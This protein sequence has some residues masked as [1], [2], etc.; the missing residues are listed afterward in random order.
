MDELEDS[1]YDENEDTE[2]N[3]DLFEPDYEINKEESDEDKFEPDD[4]LGEKETDGER[5]EPDY[6]LGEKEADENTFEPDYELGEKEANEDTFE[7]DYELDEKEADEDVFEPDYQLD[8]E[9]AETYENIDS[10][11]TIL[12][13]ENSE[14]D[15]EYQQEYN[16]ESEK[17]HEPEEDQIEKEEE[18]VEPDPEEY[19]NDQEPIYDPDEIS[20]I[21]D[22]EE[23]GSALKELHK[24]VGYSNEELEEYDN[25]AFNAEQAY[26]KMKENEQDFEEQAAEQNGENLTEEIKEGGDE[27]PKEITDSE[28][29][30]YLWEEYDRLEQEGKSLEEISELMHEAEET[31]Q[32][33]KN[34]EE[35][36]E[37]IYERQEKQDLE[38]INHK[39]E[40]ESED[41]RKE[42]ENVHE[43]EY[44][45]D[46]E[47][48]LQAE[49][50]SPEKITEGMQEVEDSYEFVEEVEAHFEQQK[51]EKLKSV[52]H[53]DEED[54]EEQREEID[55]V[56]VIECVMEA[57]E[58]FHE[59]G[60]SQEKIDEETEKIA[61]NFYKSEV[62]ELQQKKQEKG[63]SE[64]LG[65][66]ET[67]IT[68][69]ELDLEEQDRINHTSVD[70]NDE[71][72]GIYSEMEYREVL[73]EI[74]SEYKDKNDVELEQEGINES[75]EKENKLEPKESEEEEYER[76]QQL[77]RQETGK[78]PI[79]RRRE[80]IG[81]SEWLEHQKLKTKKVEEKEEK[82]QEEERWKRILKEWIKESKEEMLNSELK[83]VLKEILQEYEVLEDLCRKSVK[84]NLAETERDKWISYLRKYLNKY[85]IHLH[86]LQNIYGFKV[87][88]QECHPWEIGQIKYKFIRHLAKKY[89]TLKREYILYKSLKYNLKN[90]KDIEDISNLKT[91]REWEKELKNQIEN[92]IKT[93]KLPE[94]FKVRTLQIYYDIL[95]SIRDLGNKMVFSVFYSSLGSRKDSK[96]TAAALIYVLLRKEKHKISQKDLAGCLR[97]HR[98]AIT[99]VLQVL[100]NYLMKIP[101]HIYIYDITRSEG[102]SIDNFNILFQNLAKSLREININLTDYDLK[103]IKLIIDNWK[104][105]IQELQVK[106]F[107][108]LSSTIIYIY[109][110]FY[111]DIKIYQ[112][113]FV[114]L[115][116]ELTPL[117]LNYSRFSMSF[118]DIFK[119]YFRLNINNYKQ[120]MINYL[121]E[122][123]NEIEAPLEILESSIKLFEYAK[124][125]K[126]KIPFTSVHLKTPITDLKILHIDKDGELHYIFPQE[127]S[128][129]LLYYNLKRFEGFEYFASKNKFKEYF[130][131]LDSIQ[132]AKIKFKTLIEANRIHPLIKDVLGRL[133]RE[134]F[135]KENFIEELKT[136]LKRD[137][138]YDTD[139]ILKLYLLNLKNMPNLTPQNYIEFLDIYG[140]RLGSYYRDLVIDK[141]S[142]IHPRVFKKISKYIE[143]YLSGVERDH[144]RELFSI[145]TKKRQEEWNKFEKKYKFQWNK[146]NISLIQDI[147]VL[148]LLYNYLKSISLGQF[149]LNLFL[150]ETTDRASRLKLVAK[151]PNQVKT[152]VIW[153]FFKKVKKLIYKFP[154]NLDS[155]K[156]LEIVK[157]VYNSPNFL[158]SKAHDILQDN[159]INLNY[160]K[161]GKLNPIATE[162]PVWK[163][164]HK[165]NDFITGH[166][167]FL[168]V[169]KNYLIIADLKPRGKNEIFKAIPQLLAYAIMLKERLKELNEDKVLSLKILCVGFSKYEAWMFNPDDVKK[170]ILYFMKIEG[171]KSSVIKSTEKLIALLTYLR[172]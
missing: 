108:Y 103:S 110:M 45:I 96:Y 82:K 38:S 119:L 95:Q 165:I 61:N 18:V 11:S 129:I 10:Q 13:H 126:L 60:K 24:E 168:F 124:R 155:I 116:N 163:K 84:T 100:R 32:I 160:G 145:F 33:L 14:M 85:P 125:K 136:A 120:K 128:L 146:S 27:L 80:T 57:E 49:G 133:K 137:Y 39:N 66:E 83:L 3:E 17:Y 41:Y 51:K 78:R 26:Q 144:A 50:K 130:G 55:R 143:T 42:F 71:N 105:N 44:F 150:D 162:V 167:D 87:Y 114:S 147:D 58:E 152:N 77:Y 154:E 139:L 37:E 101:E 140:G 153:N 157:E 73:E 156:L 149:P 135:T 59:Q 171:V 69:P 53:K 67:E 141:K 112:K 36:L 40:E 123:I 5:L 148:N 172:E 117:S 93:L 70:K 89:E 16:T 102:L 98:R 65:I 29:F 22:M 9:I 19:E 170:E 2:D 159:I 43:A 121:K 72:I 134:W 75:I 63:V 76:L 56:D 161:I 28:E 15:T 164:Y 31:Y 12:V 122:Y 107:K 4:E 46:A 131:E 6:E 166:I 118:S 90:N 151:S 86:L 94:E 1:E 92:S 106:G 109:L 20:F 21:R 127:M 23:L 99:D 138:H 64:E 79:Y 113:E 52:N 8:E 7:P 35:E 97:I 62:E 30:E 142:L 132:K 169:L 48:K 54:E 74:S 68:E 111:K 25:T 88:L 115:I 47:I 91:Q 81:F 104:L 158:T 34:Y